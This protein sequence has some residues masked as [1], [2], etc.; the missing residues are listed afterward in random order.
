MRPVC[1]DL[2]MALPLTAEWLWACH[3][4][5][6][7]L[8]LL[9]CKM[10]IIIVPKSVFL[11]GEL[12]Y[13]KPLEQYLALRSVIS[14]CVSSGSCYSWWCDAVILLNSS[15]AFCLLISHL[16][17]HR[18]SSLRFFTLK[19]NIGKLKVIPSALF[20]HCLLELIHDE[21]TQ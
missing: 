2:I 14:E 9:I 6:L 5:S 16:T 12:I 11:T 13:L 4:V 8:R 17:Y 20:G 21:I 1:Q 19:C 18:F 3:L 10:G 15:S 7:N